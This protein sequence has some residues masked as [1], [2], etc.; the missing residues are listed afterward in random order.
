MKKSKGLRFMFDG[1]FSPEIDEAPLQR[2]T[3]QCD[4]CG[5]RFKSPHIEVSIDGFTIGPACILSG[6]AAVATEAKQI[7]EDPDRVARIWGYDLTKPNDRSDTSSM[8]KLYRSLASA[9]RG[10]HSFEDL[11]GGKM[12]LG[13]AEVLQAPAD[14]RKRKAA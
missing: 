12:A 10:V 2:G 11:P 6:P 8:A 5:T 13:V 3:L 7:A 14:R 9:L 1:D 4:F